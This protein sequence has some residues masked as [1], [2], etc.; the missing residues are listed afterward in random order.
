MKEAPG[1]NNVLSDAI[2]EPIFAKHEGDQKRP[3]NIQLELRIA[4]YFLQTDFEITFTGSSDLVVTVHDEP[5]FIECKGLSS[6]TKVIMR[7]KE[8]MSQLKTRYQTA[9]GYSH[10]LVVLDIKGKRLLGVWMQAMVPA[11]VMDV[12]Q[13]T[14]LQSSLHTVYQREGQRRWQ[15]HNSMRK[16]FGIISSGN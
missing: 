4:S 3:R 7:C 16:A 10:G 9:R 12:K 2:K 1:I 8:A 15:V 5:V 13:F 14:T 11:I 6:P